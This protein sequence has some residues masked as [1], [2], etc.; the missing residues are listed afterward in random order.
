MPVNE[1]P[2]DKKDHEKLILSQRLKEAEQNETVQIE[3]LNYFQD[4]FEMPPA[5]LFQQYGV[6]IED[7]TKAEFEAF[8]RIYFLEQVLMPDNKFPN[9][10]KTPDF[11][12]R[13]PIE[14]FK[15]KFRS[16]LRSGKGTVHIK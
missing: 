13:T 6:T 4:N 14:K 9:I 8:C 12:G 5:G 2:P 7:Q 16:V 1:S 10:Q 11:S 15:F 3:M